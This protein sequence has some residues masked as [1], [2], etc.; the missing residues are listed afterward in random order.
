MHVNSGMHGGD[1]R[2]ASR[3][4]FGDFFFPVGAL[5]RNGITSSHVVPCNQ[6][7]SHLT[8]RPFFSHSTQVRPISRESCA[9]PSLRGDFIAHAAR[10]FYHFLHHNGLPFPKKSS[11]KGFRGF[12]LV[13]EKVANLC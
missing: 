4:N 9:P 5:N 3:E 1:P 2:S 6:L 10:T 12:L 7:S 13:Y 8:H 11:R